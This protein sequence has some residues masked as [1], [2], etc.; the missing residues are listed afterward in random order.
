MS[1]ETKTWGRGETVNYGLALLEAKIYKNQQS[2]TVTCSLFCSC[3]T[4]PMLLC[5]SHPRVSV[6]RMSRPNQIG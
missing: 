6:E 5:A 3:P 1:W 2:L 4:R